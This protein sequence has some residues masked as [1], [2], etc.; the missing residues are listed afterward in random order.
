MRIE[1]AKEWVYKTVREQSLKVCL[2]VQLSED[3][4]PSLDNTTAKWKVKLPETLAMDG[5]PTCTSLLQYKITTEKC[6]AC[7]PSHFSHK[8]SVNKSFTSTTFSP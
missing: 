7:G 4:N 1:R 8:T 3:D 5:L 2:F 6:H